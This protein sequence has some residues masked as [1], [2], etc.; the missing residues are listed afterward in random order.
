[1]ATMQSRKCW[2]QVAHKAA[3]H[4]LLPVMSRLL[5]H[6]CASAAAATQPPAETP[7]DGVAE[8][9]V[10]VGDYMIRMCKYAQCSPSVFIH[11]L[12]LIDRL[13]GKHTLTYLNIH[14]II[15]V[16]F[17]IAAKL[18]DDE[19]FGASWYASITG[20]EPDDLNEMERMYLIEIDWTLHCTSA[21]YTQMAESLQRQSPPTPPAA[22][23]VD[24]AAQLE[25]LGPAAEQPQRQ[26]QPLPLPPAAAAPAVSAQN[27]ARS[28]QQPAEWA[29]VAALTPAPAIH[30]AGSAQHYWQIPAAEGCGGHYAVERCGTTA[31]QQPVGAIRR[32]G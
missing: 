28:T 31:T 12:V 20:V 13:A 24:P 26:Q 21:Q 7:F 8:A 6:A 5:D 19:Y 11:M 14:R 9:P 10:S 1:M 30:T 25:P 3:Y 23:R 32:R 18:N 17:V 16:A 2:S 29:A 4:P 15:A 22:R 27:T